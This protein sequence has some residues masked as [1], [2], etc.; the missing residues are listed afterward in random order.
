MARAPNNPQLYR[1]VWPILILYCDKFLWPMALLDS[2]L[3]GKVRCLSGNP[4]STSPCLNVQ[5]VRDGG[6][7]F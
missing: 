1:T 5:G 3:H 2:D 7:V 6:R 4:F